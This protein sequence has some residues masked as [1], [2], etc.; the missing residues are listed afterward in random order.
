[1]LRTR[2]TV[3]VENLKTK[4]A[5]LIIALS[6]L[7][8]VNVSAQ[9]DAISSGYAVTTNWHGEDVPYG[10]NVIAW[11][12][13]TDTDVVEVL[14]RWKRPDES[15]FAEV[16]VAI[17]GPYT[18]PDVPIGV[19]NEISDW[20]DG[21]HGITVYYA[22]DTQTPDA[23]GGWAVKAFFIGP[24]GTTKEGIEETIMIKATSFNVIPEVAIIGTAGAVVAMLLGLGFFYR[25]NSRQ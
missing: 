12:G 1:M 6:L 25:K 8:I 16:T 13:T 4:L 19:T 10:E 7:F 11:A 23:L 2:H 5:I 14:F 18:T 9:W 21:N 17:S 15:V 22:S 24:G 20:A 3:R